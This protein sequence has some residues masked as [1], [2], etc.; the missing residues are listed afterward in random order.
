MSYIQ[1][2]EQEEM[3]LKKPSGYWYSLLY[4]NKNWQTRSDTR[5]IL[6]RATIN[7]RSYS[8][9]YHIIWPIYQLWLCI[10]GSKKA[11][12]VLVYSLLIKKLADKIRYSLDF[13]S[14]SKNYISTCANYIST[15]V[16]SIN[17]YLAF[18]TYLLL[19]C[20]PLGS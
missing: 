8:I 1:I 2:V 17:T 7:C 6:K 12:W 11:Q 3:G 16:F 4:K 14:P 9:M 10:N 19:F 15:C 20:G 13:K 18:F 5:W